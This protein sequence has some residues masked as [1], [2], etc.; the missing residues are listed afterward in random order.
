MLIGS[1][2]RHAAL[3]RTIGQAF[4]GRSLAEFEP[5]MKRYVL[6]YLDILP[7]DENINIVEY[8]DRFVF[9]VFFSTRTQINEAYFGISVCAEFRRDDFRRNSFLYRGTEG[10]HQDHGICI[11]SHFSHVVLACALVGSILSNVPSSTGDSRSA[12][13]GIGGT[14]R[15]RW[16]G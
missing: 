11:S 4:T 16:Y 2:V 13:K 12:V 6:K 1:A 5:I 3:R 8:N 15:K 14:T 10:L 7:F 9:D